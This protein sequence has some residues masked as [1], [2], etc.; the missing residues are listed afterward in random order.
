MSDLRVTIYHRRGLARRSRLVPVYRRTIPADWAGLDREL[1]AESLFWTFNVIDPKHVA[2]LGGEDR[3]L[4]E[5]YRGRRLRPLVR[6][7]VLVIGSQAFSCGPW[8]RAL[9]V[10]VPTPTTQKGR[11][12]V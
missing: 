6:G 5:G 11:A 12:R 7:D 3:K 2:Q 1:L 4:N 9:P 10:D 8:G